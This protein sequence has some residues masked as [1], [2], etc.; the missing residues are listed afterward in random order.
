MNYCL[1]TLLAS[2]ASLLVWRKSVKYLGVML[3][4]KLLFKDHIDD[5]AKKANAAPF[6]FAS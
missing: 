6:S 1:Q 5:V 3:D 4:S 2:T